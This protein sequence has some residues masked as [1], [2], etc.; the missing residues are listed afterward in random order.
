M[1]AM[2]QIRHF[3]LGLIDV[4]YPE[5]ELR[6]SMREA[7]EKILD[8]NLDVMSMSYRE[9]ELKKVSFRDTHL[10][11][12][13]RRPHHPGLSG[14]DFADSGGRLLS[15]VTCPERSFKGLTGAVHHPYFYGL[16]KQRVENKLYIQP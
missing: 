14:R 13:Q 12:A 2:N 4:N 11:P 16:F 9:E 3:L 7:I 6:R 5:R 8:L 1:L 10:Y 15:R